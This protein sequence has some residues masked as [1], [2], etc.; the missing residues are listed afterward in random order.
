M[1]ALGCADLGGAV[2]TPELFGAG[3]LPGGVLGF[4][5]GFAKGVLEAPIKAGVEGA[6][7]CA[8]VPIPGLPKP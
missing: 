7:E 3:G 1:G 8:D 5:G 6:L 4:V 2:V